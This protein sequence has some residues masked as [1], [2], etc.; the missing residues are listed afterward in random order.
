MATATAA[1]MN[2]YQAFGM[3]ANAFSTTP[4]PQFAYETREHRLAMVKILYSI[5]QRMGMFLMRGDVG[6]GKTTLSRFLLQQLSTDDSYRLAY[7]SVMNQR[8]EA[9]FLRAINGAFGL[10]TPFKTAEIHKALLDFLLTMHKEDKTVVLMID[11]AQTIQS[12]NLHTLHMLLNYETAKYKLLQIVL[13]AQ[14]NFT[15]KIE[16]MPALRSRI[17][18]AAYLNPLSFEDA[19]AMLR[20]RVGQ[21]SADK[22]NF[23]HVFP[24][25][26]L[27]HAIYQAAGGVPRDLCVL[28]S[29]ALVNAFG[30]GMTRVSEEA[31][32]EAISDFR[33]IKFEEKTNA[34]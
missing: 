20:F 26:A 17:T 23:D 13:F 25:E 18:G 5:Q 9:G 34:G 22:G 29:A 11:E 30:L 16:Q 28:A 2:L 27:H 21:V 8:T 6:T 10:P 31:L 7:L 15:N 4:D 32:Q 3:R 33:S 14:P 24:T 1:G 19:I 12:R